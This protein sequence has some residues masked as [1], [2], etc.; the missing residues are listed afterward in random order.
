MQLRGNILVY[1]LTLGL[2]QKGRRGPHTPSTN[3]KTSSLI[4]S[5]QRENVSPHNF[6]GPIPID[7]EVEGMVKEQKNSR[8]SHS[9]NGIW[10]SMSESISR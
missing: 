9:E 4:L 8:L 5:H 6:T 2:P 3:H 1:F 10:V 7:S